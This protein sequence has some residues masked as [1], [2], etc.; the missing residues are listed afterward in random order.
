MVTTRYTYDNLAPGYKTHVPLTVQT[1]GFG[2]RTEKFNIGASQFEKR[3]KY[4]TNC[5]VSF[6]TIELKL[7]RTPAR[8]NPLFT[9]ILPR[10]R[11]IFGIYTVI[12]PPYLNFK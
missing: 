3:T 10:N 6:T 8:Q 7:C 5:N 11:H 12:T 1:N 4:S 2:S 9:M